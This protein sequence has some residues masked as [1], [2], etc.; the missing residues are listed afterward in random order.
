MKYAV[1]RQPYE[2][3]AQKKFKNLLGEYLSRGDIH[4]ILMI[5]IYVWML[6]QDSI[7]AYEVCFLRSDPF[8]FN[9][10]TLSYYDMATIMV[11]NNFLYRPL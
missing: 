8:L 10:K 7:R 11:V 9:G 1:K 2:I 4:S 6:F 3:Y 5:I